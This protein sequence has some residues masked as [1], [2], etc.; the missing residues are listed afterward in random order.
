MPIIA[1]PAKKQGFFGQGIMFIMHYTYVLLCTDLNRNRSKYY[2][3]STK[4]LKQ[5]ILDHKSK[6]NKTT[7]CFDIIDLIY[8]E[9]CL[10]MTDARN[11]EFQLETG[12]GRGYIKRRNENYF[13]ENAAVVQR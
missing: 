7:K 13:I 5:R 8:Y 10:N 2:I 11:R 6:S 12:F 1:G 4:N 9:A 3:G